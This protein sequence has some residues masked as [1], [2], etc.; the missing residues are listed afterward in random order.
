[1][2]PCVTHGL[3][4]LPRAPS[5]GA[6]SGLCINLAGA[7]E[8]LL[9][10]LEDAN[11]EIRGT[12]ACNLGEIDDLRCVDHLVRIIEN[13]VAEHVRSEALSAL[14]GFRSNQILECL[15][16]EVHRPKISRRPRQIVAQQLRHYSDDRVLDALSTLRTA[17]DDV[18][19]RIFAADS[20]VL[21]N[22][23]R[24][25]SIWQQA[26]NDESTYVVKIAKL[27]I[28]RLEK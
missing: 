8:A 15:I 2:Q 22:Q 19:V 3:G 5:P 18:Y 20:L 12:A 13:D 7:F 27:A 11:A 24:L 1:V 25:L 14:D 17:D 26:L 21:L 16:R 6:T 28:E 4:S 23:T 10:F 9:P